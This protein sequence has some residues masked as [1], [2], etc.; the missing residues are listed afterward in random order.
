[1]ATGREELE[2][3]AGALGGAASGLARLASTANP[4]SAYCLREL[5]WAIRL[6]GEAHDTIVALAD[7]PWYGW[8][9]DTLKRMVRRG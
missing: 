6:I 9:W 2:T 4:T 5:H 3:A 1:V 8:L 7:R